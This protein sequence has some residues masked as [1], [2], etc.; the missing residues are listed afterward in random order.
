MIN[1]PTRI[2]AHT[3]TYIDNIFSNCFIENDQSTNGI[4]FTDIS[5]HLPIF[6]VIPLQEKSEFM[7]IKVTKRCI[8]TQSK[9]HFSEELNNCNWNT[10]F[11]SDNPNTAYNNFVSTYNH[12]YEKCFPIKTISRKKVKLANKPWIT[13]GLVVSIKAKCKLYKEF[14]SNPTPSNEQKYKKYKNK[15]N[16]LLKI[17]K[18]IHYDFKFESVKGN[19]RAT[20]K[21]QRMSS[22]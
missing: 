19:L 5:D 12:I 22:R 16:S 8:N 11:N 3:A 21:L 13:K 7:N 2:T 9:K 10:V 14:L 18:R 4:F 20:W 6:T 17:S 15:L 1:R